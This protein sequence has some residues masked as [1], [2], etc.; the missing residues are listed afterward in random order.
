MVVAVS[1]NPSTECSPT[2]SIYYLLWRP[3]VNHPWHSEE[4][5]NRFDAHDRYFS[6]IQRGFEAYLEKR[7]RVLAP[8]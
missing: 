2:Q 1:S 5:F 4:L 6:L 7:K 8:A 3:R